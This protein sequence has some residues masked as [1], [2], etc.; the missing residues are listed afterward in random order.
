MVYAIAIFPKN[1]Q[2]IEK[3]RKNYYGPFCK[4]K[5]A[6]TAKMVIQ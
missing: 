5:N 1:V 6:D 4:S 3:I 2:K